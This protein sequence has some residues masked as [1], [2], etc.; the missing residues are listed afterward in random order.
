MMLDFEE[1]DKIVNVHSKEFYDEVE[2]YVER[3]EIQVD[4]K[5]KTV[6]K[7]VKPVAIPLPSNSQEKVEKATLQLNLRDPKKIAHEFID[8]VL[9]GLKVGDESILTEVEVKCFREIL[10]QYDK[11]FAFEPHEIECVDPGVVAPMVIFTILYIPW[12]LQP[13]FVLRAHLP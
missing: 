12:N 5:Y 4:T 6:A 7:K 8:M 1:K 11:A 9:S 3:Y 2:N 10:I 13:I